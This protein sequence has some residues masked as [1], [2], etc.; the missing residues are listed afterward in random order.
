MTLKRPTT[1]DTTY[2]DLN[3]RPGRKFGNLRN[4]GNLFLRSW[5]PNFRFCPTAKIE[6]S[7]IRKLRIIFPR[8]PSVWFI[9]RFFIFSKKKIF[10]QYSKVGNSVLYIY[11]IYCFQSVLKCFFFQQKYIMFKILPCRKKVYLFEM[12][13]KRLSFL[14]N[15]LKSHL[16]HWERNMHKCLFDVRH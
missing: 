11:V 15:F 9:Y 4:L 10:F 2:N 13:L 7:E 3:L 8:F 6:N 14:E 1:R 16:R 12:Y 5:N